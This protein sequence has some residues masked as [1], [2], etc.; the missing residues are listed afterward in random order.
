MNSVP[1]V[2]VIIPTYNRATYIRECIDSVLN[3]TH[4]RLEV[5]VVDDGSTDDTA[6]V[7]REYGN[8][9]RFLTQKNA[10]P[11]IARNRGIALATGDIIAFLDSDDQWLPTKL[12]RQVQSL[13]AAGPEVTCSLCNCTVLYANGNKTST[14]TLADT[15]P[16]CATGI[17]LNPVEVLLNRFVMFNQ[18]VAIR[19]EVLERVGYFDESLRFG[20]DYELPF[21]LALEGPWTIIQDELVI[22]HE[23]SPGSWA[24][25]ALR[26]E[27]RLRRD[28]VQIRMRMAAS[29]ENDPS[30]VTLR[31]PA[32]RELR[33][34]K[35]ELSIAQFGKSKLLGAAV[36]AK[37]LAMIERLRR[38]L[39]RRSP[40][41]P[42]ML[43]QDLLEELSPR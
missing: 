10:G 11:A 7:L 15:M 35:R 31:K 22:Y 8:R 17:W 43:V 3:Q 20:E 38:A 16:S 12:E 1:L 30:L 23:A 32:G 39:F 34:E 37:S 18:A 5:I 19:R 33:R 9:I 4:P 13:E 41:Y 2:S 27:I 26:E 29:I 21:R 42:R 28:L 14:F 36:I 40:F 24:K 25:T 6:T